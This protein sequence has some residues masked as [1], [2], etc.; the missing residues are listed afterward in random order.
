MRE[1]EAQP[2][3]LRKSRKKRKRN[4]NFTVEI[5]IAESKGQ[6][7]GLWRAS[8]VSLASRESEGKLLLVKLNI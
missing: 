3:G 5:G 6:L 7:N 4:T 2:G 8:L 1:I